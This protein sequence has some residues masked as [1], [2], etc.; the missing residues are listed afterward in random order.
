MPEQ[1]PLPEMLDTLG[2]EIDQAK[3]DPLSINLP[4]TANTASI[5]SFIL[6]LP[7][8]AEVEAARVKLLGK[9]GVVTVHFSDLGTYQPE[10]R[11]EIGQQR[12]PLVEAFE[13]PI[14]QRKKQLDEIALE[15]RL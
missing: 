9:S 13:G 12:K 1:K 2:K 4:Q 7:S 3:Q 11:R 6:S 5:Q 15:T 10:R 8:A 14:D